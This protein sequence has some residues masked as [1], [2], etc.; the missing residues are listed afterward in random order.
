MWSNDEG[1]EGCCYGLFIAK[2]RIFNSS[3]RL[4]SMA[5]P[6]TLIEF[7][8]QVRA[9]VLEILRSTKNSTSSS[10]GWDKTRT[11]ASTLHRLEI[12]QAKIL[13]KS[14]GFGVFCVT[15]HCQCPRKTH[16]DYLIEKGSHDV[17]TYRDENFVWTGEQLFQGDRLSKCPCSPD[18]NEIKHWVIDEIVIRKSEATRRH[19]ALAKTIS[20][21]QDAID[22]AGE[23]RARSAIR[24]HL[25]QAVLHI[26]DAI[27]PQ[28]IAEYLQS[29]CEMGAISHPCRSSFQSSDR[30]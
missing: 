22:Q 16:T 17:Q 21:V 28:A 25:L 8:V 23:G 11:N 27:L 29:L 14:V 13:E 1:V 6:I 9:D 5:D 30:K 4:H 10:F 15:R 2:L 18:S 7:F 26:N 20:C 3:L 24:E 12:L 19:D